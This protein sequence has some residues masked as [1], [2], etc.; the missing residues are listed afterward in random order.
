[1]RRAPEATKRPRRPSKRPTAHA[2][3]GA[4]SKSRSRRYPEV[5]GRRICTHTSW[6][7]SVPR[8]KNPRWDR[9]TGS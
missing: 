1:M 6:D 9:G 2:P 7:G 4:R 8:P 5:G 3:R